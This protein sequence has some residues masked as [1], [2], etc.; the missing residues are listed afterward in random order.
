M[1]GAKAY[2][3]QRKGFTMTGP[4]L[5]VCQKRTFCKHLRVVNLPGKLT[6]NILIPRMSKYGEG[7]LYWVETKTTGKFSMLGFGSCTL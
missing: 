4:Y 1:A 3:S 7:M 6:K 2:C 5:S